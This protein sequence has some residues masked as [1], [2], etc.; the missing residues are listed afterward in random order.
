LAEARRRKGEAETQET[1]ETQASHRHTPMQLEVGKTYLN[2]IGKRVKIVSQTNNEPCPFWGRDENC[3]DSYTADGRLY[4]NRE[5]YYDLVEEV[6]D[7]EPPKERTRLKP[8]EVKHVYTQDVH[9]CGPSDIPIASLTLE[10][11]DAGGGHYL[12]LNSCDFAFD[13]VE[14]IEELSSAMKALLTQAQAHDDD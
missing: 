5:S 1:K 2:R 7:T 11:M 9:S 4:H 3:T 10:T 12:V 13:S 8:V 14:E 6:T